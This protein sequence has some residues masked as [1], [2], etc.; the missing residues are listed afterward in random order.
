MTPAA[1]PSSAVWGWMEGSGLR[2][3]LF[4]HTFLCH[5]LGSATA[6]TFNKPAAAWYFLF[7]LYFFF[8]LY[9]RK[10]EIQMEIKYRRERSHLITLKVKE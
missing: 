6:D 10:K 7:Y 3:S 2:L 9:E 5:N 4:S 8:A 1:N